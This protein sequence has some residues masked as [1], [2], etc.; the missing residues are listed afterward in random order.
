MGIH[1][2]VEHEVATEAATIASL[3]LKFLIFCHGSTLLR[4][5]TYSGYAAHNGILPG[6]A[7]MDGQHGC[8]FAN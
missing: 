6:P 1:L 7:Q 5:D 3:P 2:N 8:L 4:G